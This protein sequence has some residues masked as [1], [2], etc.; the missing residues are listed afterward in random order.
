MTDRRAHISNLRSDQHAHT[1]THAHIHTDDLALARLVRCVHSHARMR[2]SL[3]SG[4]QVGRMRQN[5]SRNAAARHRDNSGRNGSAENKQ[6]CLFDFL[7]PA[8]D[9]ISKLFRVD[10]QIQQIQRI[11]IHHLHDRCTRRLLDMAKTNGR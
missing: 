10:F 11:F 1:H 4:K 8:E 5:K 7:F 6:E 2:P 9:S 3:N